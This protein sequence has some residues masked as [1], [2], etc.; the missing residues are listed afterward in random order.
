MPVN[1]VTA[2]LVTNVVNTSVASSPIT[3]A[4][5]GAAIMGEAI[6]CSINPKK[7]SGDCVFS[8]AS[9]Q[10]APNKLGRTK[11]VHT[12]AV[13]TRAGRET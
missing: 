5:A 2:V 11:E 9:R 10:D 3:A 4:N 13:S 12:V 1:G 6:P 8:P 7:R